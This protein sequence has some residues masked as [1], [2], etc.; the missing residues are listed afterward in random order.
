MDELAQRF[1]KRTQEHIK[2]VNYYAQKIGQSYPD[3]D[4]S[5]LDL[6]LDGYKYLL[7]EDRTQEE[8]DALNLATLIHIK[9]ASHH[10]EYWSNTDLSEFTRTNYTPHGIIV[11]IDMPEE[12]ITEMVCDWCA[13]SHLY[14]NTATEWFKRVNGVRWL[15]SASQVKLIWDLIKRLENE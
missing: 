3:H 6:L 13:T 11:A 9:N 14:G 2:L 5:K 8:E 12:A 15:F 10:P 7:K 4:K 1:I